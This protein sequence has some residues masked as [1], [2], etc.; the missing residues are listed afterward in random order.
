MNNQE[1][2]VIE[3]SIINNQTDKDWFLQNLVEL[4]NG[5]LSIGITLN[6][7]GTLIS[8]NLIG[9]KEYFNLFGENFA[10]GFDDKFAK[11]IKDKYSQFGAI[12]DVD[13]SKEQPKPSYIHLKDAKFY[14]VGIGGNPIP[15]NQGILWR[16]RI[17]EVSGFSLGIF[18]TSNN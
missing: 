5:S 2:E 15:T 6:V 8:G 14:G 3:T 4:T 17:S 18:N 12:Y 1:K 13:D 9:G 7:S 16:G 10:S 11:D